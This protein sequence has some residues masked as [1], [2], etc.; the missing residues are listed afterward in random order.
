MESAQDSVVSFDAAAQP[1]LLRALVVAIVSVM[2]LGSIG[3]VAYSAIE[4]SGA[5]VA[6]STSTEGLL[7]AGSVVI[8]RPE[9]PTALFFDADELY[10]GAEVRGCVVLRYDG[11]ADATLRISA[12]PEGGSGLD[13]YIDL[14]LVALADN[15]CPDDGEVADTTDARDVYDGQ[16]D[17]FWKQHRDFATGLDLGPAMSMGDDI[18]I[19]ATVVVVD[20][21][22]AGGLDTVLSFTIEARPT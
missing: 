8:S 2:L 3:V 15:A 19:E 16:L 11:T 4:T 17:D 12:Q 13:E 9:E 1:S 21:N 18:A 14:R 20:D 22:R 7:S 5:R 6:A 10:P